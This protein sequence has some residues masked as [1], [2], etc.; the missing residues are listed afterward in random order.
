MQRILASTF[1]AS[2]VPVFLCLDRD[3]WYNERNEILESEGL[4]C[5][6]FNTLVHETQTT[7]LQ[8]LQAI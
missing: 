6:Q 4:K 3:L 2:N 5:P 7:A 1:T 8:L